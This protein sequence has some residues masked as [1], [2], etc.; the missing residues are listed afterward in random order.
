MPAEL[1]S[2]I[3]DKVRDEVQPMCREIVEML[4]LV[5]QAFKTQR[6]AS[7]EPATRLGQEIHRR[8]KILTEFIVRHMSGPR[9]VLDAQSGLLFIPGHLERVGDNIEFLVR[10]VRTMIQDGIPFSDK[11]IHEMN[12]LFEK[13]IEILECIWDAITTKNRVLIRHI[14]EDG[15]QFENL[16]D[17][18]L[19]NHQQRLIE[20]VCL[21]KASSMYLA[22]V[23]YL[24]GIE[25]HTRQIGQKLS[26]GAIP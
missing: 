8:E 24:K 17:D 23:D 6:V 13:A 10:A 3:I 9:T 2:E 21:P 19:L 15:K 22:M 16:A 20:A 26:A 7:L 25:S 4:T 18:F 5:S 12:T 1:S 14:V 11:G